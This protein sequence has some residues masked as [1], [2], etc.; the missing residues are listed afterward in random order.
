MRIFWGGKEQ[1]E[2]E[3]CLQQPVIHGLTLHVD[4]HLILLTLQVPTR[5]TLPV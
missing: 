2:N 3:S 5:L 4:Y 1:F